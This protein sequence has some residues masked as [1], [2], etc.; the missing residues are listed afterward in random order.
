[1]KTVMVRAF[2]EDRDWLVSRSKKYG[3][4]SAET[5]HIVIGNLRAIEEH[6]EILIEEEVIDD[7]ILSPT[8]TD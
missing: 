3:K 4:T 8:G 2:S 6:M 7:G 5:L 1:M